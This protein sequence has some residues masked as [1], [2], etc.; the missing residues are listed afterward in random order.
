MSTADFS[1]TA[2]FLNCLAPGETQHTFQ[3]FHDQLKG[4]PGAIVHGSI[5]QLGPYL[6]ECQAAGHGVFWTVNRTDGLGRELHNI[7]A[8][9]AVWLDMD[10]PAVPWQPA[11]DALLPHAVVQSSP[12][13]YHLYWTLSDCSL[14][15]AQSLLVALRTRWG[16][17][18]GATGINRVLRLPGFLHLKT[19]TPFV[20]QISAWNP[21][22]PPYTVYQLVQALQLDLTA[23][24]AAASDVELVN[25]PVEGWRNPI[26]EAEL[27]QRLNGQWRGAP[28]PGEAFGGGWSLHE[29]WAPDLAQLQAE[30]VRSQARM[31]LLT[32]LCYLTGGDTARIHA[33]VQDHP[34]AVKD[35]REGL[36]LNELAR[37]RTAFMAWWEPEYAKRQQQ[38]HET[39][40]LAAGMPDGLR[41]TP[42]VLTSD[43]MLADLVL[44]GRGRGVVIRSSKQ[45]FKF[46]DAAGYF[47]A[48]KEQITDPETGKP[49][50]VSALNC[51]M[52]H[53]ERRLTVGVLTWRPGS[54]EFCEP[55]GLVDG[56]EVAY[57]T[58]R[59]LKPVHVPANWQDWV[60]WFEFHVAY[61]VPVES[62]RRR[63]LQWLGHIL[64]RPGELPHT[65]YLM[66]TE[67]TGTGRN[68]LASVLARVLAGYTALGV[69]LGPILDGK[70][71]GI[72]S[73]KLLA[74]VDEVR[75]GMDENRYGRGEALKK[76]ITEEQR[77]I[78]HKYGQQV[79][80]Q[81]CLRWLIFSNHRADAL[82]FDN[83][84]RR[85]EVVDNPTHRQG[86]DYYAQLYK[87]LSE[88]AFIAS[89][90]H[91]LETLDLT[92]F[93]AGAPAKLNSAKQRMI[94]AMTSST[95]K[96]IAA[97]KRKWTAPVCTMDDLLRFIK[98]ST[99]ESP[100][101]GAL[102]YALARARIEQTLETVNVDGAQ[103]TLLVLTDIPADD[104]AAAIKQA[105]A[106]MAF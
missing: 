32:R 95:D 71:N 4:Q 63:F 86:E 45:V 18:P 90:R 48:S 75:E 23:G 100:R 3:T 55:V 82:P 59:G 7:A 16:G 56:Q 9:R 31:S 35:N 14:E 77:Q 53:P 26:S 94:D 97:F 10:D 89:V 88:P 72:L 80:E 66:V 39:E 12:G 34:L 57:N 83:T 49:K 85:I 28:G 92:G 43:E 8:I 44:V 74:T 103:G 73:Q 76:V 50:K 41:I 102:R 25:G 87:L 11:A 105:R 19:D 65:G 64:Q 93:N 29:L 99:G 54:P 69:S 84:D 40:L 38:R 98:I 81:N 5:E 6:Q 22:A 106:A 51:W 67:T 70:F 17:D 68:W 79:V 61:L 27:Q 60:K 20:T 58:W 62:E 91:Y 36:L 46:D 52:G 96:A 13:K 24:T 2:A 42:R 104:P 33:L 37:A 21:G 78:D 30:G 15:Q 1:Y 47:A 101:P